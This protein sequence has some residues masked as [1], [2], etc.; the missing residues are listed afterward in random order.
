MLTKIVPLNLELALSI[1]V[2]VQ[3]KFKGETRI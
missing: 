3:I 1:K 2:D